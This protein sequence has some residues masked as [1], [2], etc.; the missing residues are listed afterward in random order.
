MTIR[1]KDLAVPIRPKD[2]SRRCSTGA[3]GTVT[4]RSV[5][6]TQHLPSVATKGFLVGEC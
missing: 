5:F 4:F 1:E 6:P 2:I 3:K